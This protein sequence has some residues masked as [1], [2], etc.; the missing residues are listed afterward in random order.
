VYLVIDD[1]TAG[2]A[3]IVTVSGELDMETAPQLRMHLLNIIR[4]DQRLV[5]VD[6]TGLTFMDSTGL[7]V[8]LSVRR[9]AQLFDGT[10]VLCGLQTPVRRVLEVTGLLGHFEI[11][12][13]A[14]AAIAAER[15]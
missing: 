1:R 3:T 8:L 15:T 4:E 11:H 12:P 6:L 5:V 10:L 9:R 14:E 13:D 7:Q 2:P